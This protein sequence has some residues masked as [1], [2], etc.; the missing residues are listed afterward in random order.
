MDTSSSTTPVLRR[1]DVE[2]PVEHAGAGVVAC[3]HCG[4]RIDAASTS[5]AVADA[6]EVPAELGPWDADE[7]RAVRVAVA[8]V[9]RVMFEVIAGRRLSGQLDAVVS[10]S[11]L[12][13]VRAARG[14]RGGGC[15]GVPAL[16]EPHRCGLGE[17]GR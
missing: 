2:P 4:G 11:V 5:S 1:I 16:R 3:P 17:R 14:A 6:A 9:L 7:V 8:A 10:P 15:G 13:Y 12:R